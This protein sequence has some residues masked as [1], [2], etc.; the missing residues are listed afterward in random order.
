[1]SKVVWFVPNLIG[2]VR[3]ILA[4]IAFYF[5]FD[6]PCVFLSCY[7]LSYLL[8]ALDGYAARSLNQCSRFGAVLD[9]ICDRFC[10]ITIYVYL[11]HFY[12]SMNYFFVY[13]LVMEIIS[14]W[15]QMYCSLLKAKTTH[16]GS[17]NFLINLFYKKPVLFSVCCFNEGFLVFMYWL[18]FYAGWIVTL[19]VIGE[20]GIIALFAY[21]CIPG[22]IF[23]QIVHV[24]QFYVSMMEIAQWDENDR[25]LAK[26]S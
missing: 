16:K 10:T 19:P 26:Q 4:F 9:M 24:V 15:A 11:T 14:H 23:K 6:K 25:R 5:A 12:K 18:N 21:I 3:I 8:D 1:M 7:S 17:N 20:I 22:F 13:C 2:Y